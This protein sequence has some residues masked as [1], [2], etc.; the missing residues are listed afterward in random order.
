MTIDGMLLNSTALFL[1]KVL[2][3]FILK[4]LFTCAYCMP[5][6]WGTLICIYF[7]SDFTLWFFSFIISVVISGTLYYG[8]VK[9][10]IDN[11]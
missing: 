4:P 7:G 9:K 3:K 10:I 6:F 5:S 8:L 1:E 2:P 11:V